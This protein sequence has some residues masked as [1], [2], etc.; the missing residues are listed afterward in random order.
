M[1]EEDGGGVLSDVQNDA[2]LSTTLEGL[3]EVGKI[4]FELS[5][6]A[7]AASPS[8]YAFMHYQIHHQR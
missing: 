4:A 1:T 2:E 6:E 8:D 5:L 3:I 7:T